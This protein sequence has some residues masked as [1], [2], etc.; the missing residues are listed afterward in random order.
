MWPLFRSLQFTLD[1]H[2]THERT[3]LTVFSW[4]KHKRSWRRILSSILFSAHKTCARGTNSIQSLPLSLKHS[5]QSYRWMTPE[6]ALL[7]MTY[8][9]PVNEWLIHMCRSE[10]YCL[11]AQRLSSPFLSLSCAYTVPVHQWQP[12]RVTNWLPNIFY[13]PTAAVLAV[14]NSGL[15]FWK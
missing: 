6:L 8:S 3:S 15:L 10:Y 2:G 4:S 11:N 1:M 14:N 7:P 13:P 9:V 5:W 12:H